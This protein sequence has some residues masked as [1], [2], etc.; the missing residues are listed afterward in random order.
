MEKTGNGQ[1][2][3]KSLNYMFQLNHLNHMV[4]PNL[5]QFSFDFAL[6]SSS[7]LRQTN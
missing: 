5:S 4:T 2:T 3:V 7:H 1:E 6:Y